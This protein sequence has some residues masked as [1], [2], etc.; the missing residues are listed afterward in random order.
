MASIKVAVRCRPFSVEDELGVNMEQDV[1]EESGVTELVGSKYQNARFPFSWSWWSAYGYQRKLK[2]DGMSIADGMTLTDQVMVYNQCGVKILKEF[3]TGDTIVIFAYGLSG[4]G[5]TYTVFGPDSVAS[6]DAWFK[7]K[8]QPHDLWGVFPRFTWDLFNMKQDN[9]EIS[10]RYFQNMVNDVRDL[11]SPTCEEHHYKQGLHKDSSGFMEF[12]WVKSVK[13]ETFSD[14]C[15]A[16]NFSNSQKGIA[17]TQFNHQSTRGHCILQLECKKPFEDD[18]NVMVTCR[19]YVCD[20]AGTEPAADIYSA[21]YKR[22]VIDGR[23]EMELIGQNENK[24]LSTELQ[25][26]GKKINLSLTEMAQFFMKM[27]QASKSGKLKPGASIPGCN[28][29]FLCKYLK[30]TMLMAKTYLFCAIRPEKKYHPYSYS[31]LVFA[32]NASV[33]KLKPKKGNVGGAVPPHLQKQMDALNDTIAEQ[34]NQDCRV[35]EAS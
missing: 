10:L 9:W 11:S 34:K 1:E 4:S 32:K 18:P 22:H 23:V 27:A 12:D 30:D 25:N 26:Q 19:M 31:T 7:H 14:L 15:D 28:S 35:R 29:Y 24:A 8:T 33:I 3:L 17:S 2:G 5:K 6:P 13:L 20:L 16:I 21:V